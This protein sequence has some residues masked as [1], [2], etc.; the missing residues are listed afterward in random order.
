M[1][2]SLFVLACGVAL[3]AAGPSS[4]QQAD[5][6]VHDASMHSAPVNEKHPIDK[7]QGTPAGE[8]VDLANNAGKAYV[9]KPKG[10]PKAG[11]VVFHEWW[12]LNDQIKVQADKLAKEGYLVIAPDLYDGKVTDN[13]QEAGKIMQSRDEKKSDAAEDAAIAWL[14][15][16]KSGKKALKVGALGWCMG[17]GE[18]LK[19]SIRH[20]EHVDA[21]VMYYGFPVSDPEQLKNIKGPLLAHWA[22]KDGW[23]KA[24]M[25]AGFKDALKKAGVKATHYEY[26]ADHAFANPTGG[27]FNPPAAKIANERTMAFLKKHL[28]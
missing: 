16:Q 4:A 23:I 3:L 20:G 14:H 6:G 12:G 22:N 15:D 17:G 18:S 28:R 19:S 21:T 10:Q 27:A 13:P 5:A 2:S 11:L 26:D 9:A 7:N 25:V 1:K 24:D 8:M